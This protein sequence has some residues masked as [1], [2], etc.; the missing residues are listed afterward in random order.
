VRRSSGA[1]AKIWSVADREP[2]FD[3]FVGRGVPKQRLLAAYREVLAGQARLVLVSG[4][5]GIG[6]TSL[7]AEAIRSMAD[8]DALSAWGTCWD[9]ERAPGYWPWTQVLREVVNKSDSSLL[10]GLTDADR[11]DLARLLPELTAGAD[12]GAS[13]EF[14]AEHAQ[15]RLFDAVTRL[16]ERAAKRRPLI[17]V[18]DDLQW[19]DSSSLAL[20]EFLVR[21]YRPVPLLVL[22]TYRRDE[23]RDDAVA[24]LA[25]LGGSAE[26]VS[27]R[28]LSPGE[29]HEL[30]AV[31]AGDDLA[32]RWS[33]AVHGRTDGHPFLVRELTHAFEV[34]PVGSVSGIPDA[35]H[36]LIASRL[37]RLSPR[38]RHLV[39]AAAV[40]GNELLVDVLGDVLDVS[41]L[42][43]ADLVDEGVRAG[44]LATSPD[45][46]ARFAHD[47][48]RET[49]YADLATAAKASLHQQIGTALEKRHAL[50]YKGF[51]GQ[52]AR[53]FAEAVAVDGPDRAIRWALIAATD[54]QTRLAFGE[55]AAQIARVRSALDDAGVA[56][57]GETLVDLL[58]AQADAESRAGHGDR[59]RDLL[60]DAHAHAVRAEDPERLATVALAFQ[61]LGARFAMPRAEVVD[62]LEG[63]LRAIEGRAP[64]LEAEVTASLARELYHSV[65][66][67][68]DR[69]RPLSEHAV[70]LARELDDPTTLAACLLAQHDVLWTPGAG[71]ERV[72]V[73]HEIVRLAERSG[74]DERLSQGHLLAANALLEL[75][76]PGFDAELAV[77]LRLEAGFAQPRHDYLAL[78]RRAALAL[79]QG[80]IDEG[81]RL[82]HEAAALG[83]RIGEPDVGNVQMSQLLEVARA[84]GD[85]EEMCRTARAAIEWWVGIPS[86]AHGVAAGLFAKAGDVRAARRALD[87]VLELGTW[88]QDRSYIW[89]VFAS[90]LAVAAHALEDHELSRQLLD[91]FM[92]V[93]DACGVNGAVVCFTGSLAHPAGLVAADIGEHEQARALLLHAVA[94]HARL[95]ARAWEAETCA[96]LAQ[97]L[98][99][100][101]VAYR[102]RAAALAAELGLEG[103]TA[104]L[105]ADRDA[106][107]S[108]PADAVCRR[109]GDLWRIA[110]RDQTIHL[111]DAKGL[112]DLA[113]LLAS[114]G[115]DIHVLDLTDSGVDVQRR[116]DP[117]LDRRARVEYRRRL[118]ELDD[119][120]NQAQQHHDLGQIERIEVERDLVIAEIRRATDHIGRDRGLGANV[121]ER[122]RKA[123]TG[124]LRDTIRRVESS[125]PELGQHLDRSIITG[126]HCRYQPTEPLAWDVSPAP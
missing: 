78:T 109:D 24:R 124:R 101:G 53:H 26:R 13:D 40:G 44:V 91:E 49:L 31:L 14:D 36:D 67:E 57:P 43:I 121:V 23:L 80:A 116:T 82:V 5:A 37:G 21:A 6:K 71:A 59:A 115:K 111:R 100:E 73:A 114:P 99:E 38:C 84:R 63:A 95:G 48:Y 28:G 42:A 3:R 118:A 35:A 27:L 2:G 12:V 81:D 77:F 75:G 88:R 33:A 106:R 69:A 22:G 55:A 47:L 34:D 103:L 65:P 104:R 29:V 120:L 68:R 11:I 96:E 119:D 61:R 32:D 94:V 79:M 66:R 122:A 50:G 15:L 18:L 7:V 92:P 113:A 56:V 102:A 72:A 117:I 60:R 25:G 8:G 125:L 41:S 46:R 19:A 54:D 86:H 17:L 93:A 52:V 62:L 98:G 20:L 89:S 4:E 85:P 90:S 30:I 83:E 39:D 74:D 112:H 16:L 70:A 126:T 110:Y 1:A 51:S 105:A 10:A 123:V 58:V 97:L 76:S 45:H 108:A 87:T 64:L 9:A 107:V